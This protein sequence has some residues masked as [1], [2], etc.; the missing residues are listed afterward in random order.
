MKVIMEKWGFVRKIP[1]PFLYNITLS[2]FLYWAELY[3]CEIKNYPP[4]LM[5]EMRNILC[6]FNV[7]NGC[8]NV[9]LQLTI[10][11]YLWPC[12]CNLCMPAMVTSLFA[13]PNPFFWYNPFSLEIDYLS[14][15]LILSSCFFFLMQ[16]IFYNILNRK[17]PWP[18]IP[19]S[20]SY[21]A[22]DF[23]NRLKNL[24]AYFIFWI[25]WCLN[26]LLK[27]GHTD[28]PQI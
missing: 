28:G 1:W 5:E 24:F 25:F 21:E 8:W 7:W 4:K 23:I 22:Q 13:W 15:Q 2:P 26:H 3:C 6:H 12:N 14:W 16:I 18:P 10:K 11:K 27:C 9:S 20:M 17:I 19:D